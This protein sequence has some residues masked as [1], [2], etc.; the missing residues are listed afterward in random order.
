MKEL[1]NKTFLLPIII[2]CILLAGLLFVNSNLIY[3]ILPEQ[4]GANSEENYSGQFYIAK[5]DKILEEGV[6][7]QNGQGYQLVRVIILS[8]TEEGNALE[9][10]ND[11][12]PDYAASR[13]FKEGDE[14][15][16]NHNILY[17]DAPYVITERFRITGVLFIALMFLLLVLAA[18]GIKGITS[19]LGLAFSVAI[20]IKFVVPAILSGKDPLIVCLIAAFVIATVAIYLAHGFSRR[21]TLAL[22]STLITVVFSAIIGILFVELTQIFGLGSE[23]S[24]YLQV[25]GFSINLKGLLMGGIILGA[26]GVLD[27]VTTAQTAAIDEIKNANPNLDFQELYK[28]GLS[29]GKEHISSLINTLALAYIGSSF[30]LLLLFYL[31]TFEPFWITLNSEFMVEEIVRTLVGSSVLVLAVP[32]STIIAAKFIKKD[33]HAKQQTSHAHHH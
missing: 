22:I 28:R 14:V 20:L 26:L 17:S 11:I 25:T 4:A 33:E 9:I 15:V 6:D 21:T 2:A 30:P 24:F 7:E 3:K 10:R 19:L 31:N 29:V 13:H 18:S 5:V 1:T 23:E 12:Q 27:D 16:V 8:G 32:I